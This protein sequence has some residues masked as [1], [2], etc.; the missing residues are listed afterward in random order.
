MSTIKIDL[1]A[2]VDMIMVNEHDKSSLRH[3]CE[4]LSAELAASTPK[5]D[6]LER[7]LGELEHDFLEA[8]KANS[9]RIKELEAHVEVGRI[10]LAERDA[11]IKDLEHPKPY[12]DNGTVSPDWVQS[13]WKIKN[14]RIEELEAQLQAL[15]EEFPP[16]VFHGP[17]TVDE[18]IAWLN[19]PDDKERPTSDC[20]AT[21]P[22][23]HIACCP[24]CRDIAQRLADLSSANDDMALELYQ[25]RGTTTES[26]DPAATDCW[27]TSCANEVAAAQARIKELEAALV[28]AY[29]DGKE[30]LRLLSNETACRDGAE[31][32]LENETMR[33]DRANRALGNCEDR[34][35]ELAE[36]KDG[37]WETALSR[38][39]TIDDLAERIKELETALANATYNLEGTTDRA[40]QGQSCIR[41][42]RERLDELAQV[43]KDMEA[44]QSA[45]NLAQLERLEAER[46]HHRAVPDLEALIV[47]ANTDRET[48][49]TEA[50]AAKEAATFYARALDV[51][52]TRA[53]KWKRRAR[54]WKR[55]A[56]KAADW[57]DA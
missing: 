24:G 16:D 28:T 20:L 17:F 40:A 26:L 51:Q 8:N 48:W 29:A 10:R 57:Q 9:V 34:A 49:Y 22:K 43:I 55:A 7:T 31:E 12:L 36:E 33:A 45:R 15:L 25:I 41:S 52:Y 14:A 6:G 21:E 50:K 2:F 44:D 11:R 1:T 37:Y 32:L 35:K 18:V 3:K 47:E 46:C 42:Q 19:E 5:I 53:Q 56:R 13:Q 30:T 23:A 38:Q 54:K 39:Q 27:C 4:D